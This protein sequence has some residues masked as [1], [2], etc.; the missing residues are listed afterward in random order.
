MADSPSDKQSTDGVE[1][2][3]IPPPAAESQDPPAAEVDDNT[4]DEAAA[5]DDEDHERLKSYLRGIVD[6]YSAISEEERLAL[7][8]QSTIT[9]SSHEDQVPSSNSEE[10]KQEA[11]TLPQHAAERPPQEEDKTEPSSEPTSS[12]TQRKRP[13]RA[14]LKMDSEEEEDKKPRAVGPAKGSGSA[15]SRRIGKEEIKRREEE[16]EASLQKRASASAEL[17]LV[18]NF[19]RG[20]RKRKGSEPVGASAGKKKEAA[21]QEALD[22]QLEEKRLRERLNGRR[23]RAKKIIVIDCLNEQYHNLTDENDRLKKENAE[24][25]GKIERVRG[26]IQEK[27]QKEHQRAFQQQQQQQLHQQQHNSWEQPWCLCLVQ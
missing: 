23:K 5:V 1:N 21:K 8:E 6:Q 13:R 2:D 4:Q 24:I 11:T 14:S 19:S 27:Q 15:K 12:G 17:G 20:Q 3:Q 10:E 7:V 18:S 25:R 22:P 9:S 26:I 16:L